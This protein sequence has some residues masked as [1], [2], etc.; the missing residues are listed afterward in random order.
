[1]QVAVAAELQVVT[2]IVHFLEINLEQ[3]VLVEVKLELVVD[4][5]QLI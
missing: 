5:T 3:E 2:D 4:L 1:M